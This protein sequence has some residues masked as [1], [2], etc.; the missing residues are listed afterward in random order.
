[1]NISIPA[2]NN[3]VSSER[4]FNPDSITYKCFKFSKLRVQDFRLSMTIRKSFTQNSDNLKL[5]YLFTFQNFLFW[6]DAKIEFIRCPKKIFLMIFTLYMEPGSHE[7][8]NKLNSKLI[9]SYVFLEPKDSNSESALIHDVKLEQLVEVNYSSQ[10]LSHTYTGIPE[11]RKEI[12]H[13]S[14]PSSTF[15]SRCERS[16]WARNTCQ[17]NFLEIYKASCLSN[18]KDSSYA[19][20]CTFPDKLPEAS[21][22][23]FP[24]PLG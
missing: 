17:H 13:P 8:L 19:I 9:S 22:R 21:L 4:T 1:M 11:I 5:Y 3:V 2:Q 20:Q 23:A 7:G 24:D 10:Y 14:F 16:L 6:N 18:V 15:S 12:T